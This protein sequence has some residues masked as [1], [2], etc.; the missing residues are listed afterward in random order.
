MQVAFLN[1]FLL[2]RSVIPSGNLANEI[3]HQHDTTYGLWYANETAALGRS[4]HGNVLSAGY[5]K[6]CSEYVTYAI[7]WNQEY[8]I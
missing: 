7:E 3:D 5:D 1:K 8:Y 2:Q 6:F 4:K